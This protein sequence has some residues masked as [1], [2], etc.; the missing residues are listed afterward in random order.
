MKTQM[1]LR[2]SIVAVV[3]FCS[4]TV[5]AQWYAGHNSA[6]GLGYGAAYGAYGLGGGFGAQ[7][8]MSANAIGMGSLVRSQGV[9]NELTSQA[10]INYE[11]ARSVYIDNQQ[12]A[13]EARQARL[14]SGNARVAAE[15][16]ASIASLN[17]ANEFLASHQALPLPTS[18][19]DQSTGR[20]EWPRALAEEHDFDPL[21]K[22]LEGLFES[23]IKSGPTANVSLQIEKK[24]TELK[25]LLREHITKIPLADY[26]QARRFLDSMMA[27]AR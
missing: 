2:A 25:D 4:S 18:Q 24:T 12:K 9:Y 22:D 13:Y 27:S 17:R 3:L 11:Q 14:R 15:T 23:R 5:E 10:A 16:E 8:P 6:L 7:T 26:S 1:G 20:I 21:R 19:L